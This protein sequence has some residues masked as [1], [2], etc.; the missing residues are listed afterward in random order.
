MG[1]EIIKIGL[2]GLGMI[3]K[4]HANAYNSIPLR[5]KSPTVK[6]EV[7]AI[8][9]TSTGRD[10]EFLKILGNPKI[11]TDADTFYNEEIDL[12]DICTPNFLHREQALEALRQG[13]HVYV[14]KP[15]G[16]D[17]A[18]ARAMAEAAQK[19]DTITHTAFMKRYY[20]AVQQARAILAS[21]ELGEVYSFRV[22]FYHNSY[23]DPRRPISWRLQHAPSGGGALSDLGVHIIDLT[24]YLLGEAKWVQGRTRTF[25][26]QRPKSLGCSELV[27]VDVDDW[28]VLTVGM[29]NGAYGTIEV[30]RMSG[31]VGDSMRMEVLASNGSVVVDLKDPFHCE[32]YDQGGK[33][34]HIGALDFPMPNGE[35]DRDTLWPNTKMPVLPF[36]SAHT[37]CITDLLLNIKEKKPSMVNFMDAVKTQEILE[38]GYRSAARNGETI[39]LPLD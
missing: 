18:H 7:R 31:G 5:Y 29:E 33:R 37:A 12:V 21:G 10:E 20:P 25:I 36:D 9:R 23:M 1:N 17:L 15:P 8:L 16:W 35:R 13:K 39:T 27:A 14:E 28:G 3:G 24:R 26:T 6:A 19:S 38:A 30:T 22:H 2:I 11:V 32:Y 34:F 4:V